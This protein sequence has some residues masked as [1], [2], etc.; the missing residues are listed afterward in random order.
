MSRSRINPLVVAL[1]F[2]VAGLNA[3]PP[4][5]SVFAQEC[6]DE[7]V[8]GGQANA[9]PRPVSTASAAVDSS[10]GTAGMV[11]V[12]APG[13]TRFMAVAVAPDGSSYGAGFITV[14]GDQ[15]MA[16]ARITAA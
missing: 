8:P 12:K 13:N 4:L 9:A 15:A 5:A 1:V 3:F 11:R 2:V 16:V 7:Q 10:F 6:E 14:N